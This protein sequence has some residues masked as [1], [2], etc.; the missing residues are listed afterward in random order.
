MRFKSLIPSVSVTALTYTI[1][2]NAIII[3]Q[4]Y[5]SRSEQLRALFA[6]SSMDHQFGRGRFSDLSTILTQNIYPGLNG[7]TFAVSGAQI[8]QMRDARTGWRDV[9]F[10]SDEQT[11]DEMANQIAESIHGTTESGVQGAYD[12]CE[13]WS[14][15]GKCILIQVLFKANI[16]RVC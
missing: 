1:I 7:T 8:L 13:V 16:K 15:S 2:A 5:K 10:H 4:P 3:S 11:D 9:H 14:W 12:P 6:S